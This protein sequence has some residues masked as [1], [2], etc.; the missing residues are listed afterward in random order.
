MQRQE[1]AYLLELSGFEIV[2][3]Y[4]DYN[5]SPPAYGKEQIWIARRR[6]VSGE[7]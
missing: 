7:Q 1:T 6:D 3:E 2:A 5:R 4:S